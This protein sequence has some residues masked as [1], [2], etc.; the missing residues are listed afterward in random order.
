LPALAAEQ[1]A[2]DVLRARL[3]GEARAG[4]AAKAQATAVAQAEAAAA[5]PA[6]AQVQL[7]ELRRKYTRAKNAIKCTGSAILS[8]RQASGSAEHCSATRE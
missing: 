3:T 6:E 4:A 1:S 7:S 2:R 8:P 5:A